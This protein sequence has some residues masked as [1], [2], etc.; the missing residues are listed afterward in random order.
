MTC[1]IYSI[2]YFVKI[3]FLIPYP[4]HN[5][6]FTQFIKH[7]TNCTMNEKMQEKFK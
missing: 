4:N 7:K 5:Q 1:F 2:V 3:I 6:V